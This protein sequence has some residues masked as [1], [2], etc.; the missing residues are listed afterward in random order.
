MYCPEIVITP[1][2]LPM[3]MDA[4]L[5]G[6]LVQHREAN[7]SILTFL[8]HIFDPALLKRVPGQGAAH[9]T[10]AVVPRLDALLRLTLAGVV[11]ALPPAREDRLSDVLFA[12]LQVVCW[13]VCWCEL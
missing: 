13:C 3:L 11:G 1:E 12:M 2:V 6:L 9:L 7:G 8:N 5:H 10:D 4:A